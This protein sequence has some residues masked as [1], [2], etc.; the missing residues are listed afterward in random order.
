MKIFKLEDMKSGWFIG[1]FQPTAYSTP[2]FEVNYRT[3]RAD[4]EWPHHYHTSSTEINL[5]VSGKMVF[6]GVTLVEGD[7]FTVEPYQISDQEFVEDTTVIC[8]RV[9]SCQDKIV[10]TKPQL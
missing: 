4:E 7:I 10:V 3:H 9:P 6:N 5:I 1:N 8:V 2:H